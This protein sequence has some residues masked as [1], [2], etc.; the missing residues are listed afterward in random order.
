VTDPPAAEP[1]II[2]TPGRNTS[3]WADLKLA[4]A[5]A[6]FH[7]LRT[8]VGE[9]H[10]SV[11][12]TTR[13]VQGSNPNL[14]DH[15]LQVRS[16][17]PVQEWALTLGDGLHNLRSALDAIAW[18]LAHLDG[19]TP[20]RPHRVAFPICATAA[21]WEKAEKEW[22]GELPTW[23]RERLRFL[24]PF[25][26]DNPEGQPFSLAI[27]HSLDI[28]DKHKTI[29]EVQTTTGQMDFFTGVRYVDTPPQQVPVFLPPGDP[30][31]FEDGVTVL[32]IDYLAPVTGLEDGAVT[33][34]VA[35]A[36]RWNGLV[37]PV[38]DLI[39][40]AGND[41]ARAMH[42]IR[43]GVDDSEGWEAVPQPTAT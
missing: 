39:S 15:V 26:F 16:A 20:T 42:V 37:I 38:P 18:D 43:N 29:L 3:N 35:L 32:T 1:P 12:A 22:V 17:P 21:D 24:Q 41:V 4:R 13:S 28:Q 40:S 14:V 7:A 19:R 11:P 9:F 6:H 31:P 25:T 8:R 33:P 2:L 36:V 30:R 34:S 27:L 5:H 23:A 10:A